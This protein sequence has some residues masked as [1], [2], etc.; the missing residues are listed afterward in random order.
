VR[1]L[2][3]N[4]IAAIG[5]EYI[6]RTRKYRGGAV[7]FT[8]KNPNN[9]I[10][11]GL[12]H[13]ILPHA[14]I[15]DA[16]RHPLDTCLGCYKQLFAKGQSYSYE[17][18]ELGEYY[19][20]YQRLMD[21]WDEVLP[22]KVLHVQYEDVVADL[23]SQVRTILAYCGLPWDDHCLRFFETRRDVRT[24]SSEQVREPIYRSSVS[25]WRHYEPR[26]GELIDVLR[27]ELLK[28]PEE[29]QP[30]VLRNRNIT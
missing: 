5:K 28:L 9:F 29:D 25:L 1:D 16:R 17:L 2:E 7:F 11:V 24:A 21:H 20:Q 14:R 4:A 6:E 8:D 12:L 23:E 3:D 10:H 30:D 13:L 18:E 26:L 22:G 27:P 15:I 19:L